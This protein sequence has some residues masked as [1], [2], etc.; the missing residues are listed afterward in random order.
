[1]EKPKCSIKGCEKPKR[2]R[3]MCNSHYERLRVKGSV[4]DAPLRAYRD[5]VNPCA[6]GGCSRPRFANLM[7]KAHYDRAK[8]GRPLD[9]PIRAKTP[10]GLTVEEAFAHWAGTEPT[11]TGCV[12]WAGGVLR[13][14]YGSLSVNGSPKLAHRASWERANGRPVPAG[15]VVRHTCDV[16]LCVAADHLI[17]GTHADNSGDMTE[18]NRQALGER[19]PTARMTEDSVR[20]LRHLRDTG[21][22]YTQLAERFGISRSQVSNIVHRVSWKHVL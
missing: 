15:L 3:G 19:V 18:R 12:I 9:A 16:P 8:S 6:V 11:D 21:M 10:A 2:S 17:L 14:G 20:E 22:T 7:C 1:M 5:Y 13:S 4:G